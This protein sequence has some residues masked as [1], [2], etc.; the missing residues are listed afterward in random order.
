MTRHAGSGTDMTA[1]KKSVRELP[2]QAM[3]PGFKL[4]IKCLGTPGPY[5]DWFIDDVK[6]EGH[7]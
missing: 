6:I 1:Y 5:D 4:R 7:R 3:V 2:S